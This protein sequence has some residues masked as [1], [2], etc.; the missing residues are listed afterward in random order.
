MQPAYPDGT[1]AAYEEIK[2]GFPMARRNPRPGTTAG[3][4]ARDRFGFPQGWVIATVNG[5]ERD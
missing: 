3:D 2:I 1:M 4:I 5:V